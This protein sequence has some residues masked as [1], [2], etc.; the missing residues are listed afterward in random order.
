MLLSG[1]STS[2]RLDRFEMHLYWVGLGL[3]TGVVTACLDYSWLRQ[4][5]LGYGLVGF[6]L[7]LLVA[8]LIPGLGVEKN[9][10]SRWLWIGQPS[11]L[12]KVALVI[13]LAGYICRNADRMGERKVGFLYPGGV[14]AVFVGL[15][16]F[17]PDWGTAAPLSVV[18]LAMLAV[19]GAHWAY[20]VSASLIGTELFLLLLLQNPLRLERVLA[21]LDPEK[22]RDGAGWQGWQSLLA[23]GSGGWWGT[24]FGEGRHKHGFVPEQQTDFVLSLVGEELGLA[25]TLV[26]LGLFGVLLACG[27]RITWRSADPFGKLLAAGLSV[28]ISVQAFI[29]IGV[30]TSSLPNKG[31]ALPFVSYGGSSLVGFC[32]AAGL[33]LSVARYAPLE[34]NDKLEEGRPKTGRFNPSGPVGSL[35]Y[36]SVEE[37]GKRRWKRILRR[38]RRWFQPDFRRE[39]QHRYQKLPGTMPRRGG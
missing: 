19:G 26:V 16:F 20:L 31:I 35:L 30:V 39:P 9:G 11:E 17:E 36:S 34:R 28:L 23:L 22:H 4:P 12:A 10:A 32:L 8:V 15:I 18:T 25:G 27:A 1:A 37:T 14:A 3:V 38:L 24:S 33:L 2:S 29:N 21:F 13:Y 5:R 7:L 6:M